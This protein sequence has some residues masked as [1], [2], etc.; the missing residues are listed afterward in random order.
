VYQH[1]HRK[2]KILSMATMHGYEDVSLP[3]YYP[4]CFIHKFSMDLIK[5]L[6]YIAVL[7]VPFHNL[8]ML[9]SSCSLYWG[10]RKGFYH[11]WHFDEESKLLS[12]QEFSGFST[13]EHSL[14]N[15]M[16]KSFVK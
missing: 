5:C 6:C 4:P 8:V 15:S 10:A 11:L 1:C 14:L 2:T 3:P 16:I 13:M 12:N 9:S 7:S